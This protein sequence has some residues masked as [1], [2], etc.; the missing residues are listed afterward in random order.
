MPTS[1][2]IVEGLVSTDELGRPVASLPIRYVDGQA[3]TNEIGNAVTA[4]HAEVLDAPSSVP[5]RVVDGA[6]TT[7]EIGNAVPVVPVWLGGHSPARAPLTNSSTAI[8]SGHSLTDAYVHYGPWPGNF[9]NIL[10]SLGI[11][12]VE[13]KHITSATPGSW[14]RAR[15][16]MDDAWKDYPARAYADIAEY[17]T[18]M[19]TEAGPPPHYTADRPFLIT[20]T[21]DYLC[22]FAANTIENGRGNEVVLWSIW[23]DLRGPGYPET[24]AGWTGREFRE[25]LPDYGRTF[26]FMAD[27]VGWKMRQLY[28]SLPSNYRVWVIP[29]HRWMMRVY[30]DID[31]GLVP[32]VTDIADLFEDDIHPN[33]IGVYGLASLAVTCLYQ[34]NLTEQDD[35]YVMP[36]Y[37]AANQVEWPAVSQELAEYFWQIA[38]EIATDYE[39][40]GMGGSSDAAPMWTLAQDGDLMP[41]WTLADPN[42]DP[43]DPDPEE[44]EEPEEPSLPDDVLA[45]VTADAIDGLT[46]TPALPTA[47]DGFRT[48]T[49]QHASPA[50]APVYTCTRFKR[51]AANTPI[52][53]ALGSGANTWS[54]TLLLSAAHGSWN[55]LIAVLRPIPGDETVARATGSD[56]DMEP[57]TLEVWY[58]ADA[59]T[60]NACVDGGT[61]YIAT[62]PEGPASAFG[63]LFLNVEGYGYDLGGLIAMDRVPTSAERAGIRAAL[64]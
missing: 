29:G 25:A 60:I 5:A 36:A 63:N 13:D 24:Y 43:I 56:L 9:R 42:T 57:H 61:V 4:I 46:F 3:A 39:P 22:R 31:L 38:W 2:R 12:D 35:V 62:P 8:H 17:D 50:T 53:T 40:A 54:G 26:R 41:Q 52:F 27:Y 18:L 14:I 7:N 48:L 16:E 64:A 44:P 55:E 59:G 23:P 47:T 32:G 28:P 6:I 33:P 20:E 37:T 21:L 51:S 11:T 30:D 58:D 45:M 15:Y 19:I 1:I 49:E 34:I 10:T